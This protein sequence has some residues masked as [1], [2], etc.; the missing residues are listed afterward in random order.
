MSNF[1]DSFIKE[2]LVSKCYLDSLKCFST[3]IKHDRDISFRADKFCESILNAINSHNLT[4]IIDLFNYMNCNLFSKLE[5][6]HLS[7]LKKIQYGI[8]K[9]YLVT[10][11]INGRS[12]KVQDFFSQLGTELASVVE[13]K[14]WFGK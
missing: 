6:N 7:I 10:S 13:W 1:G 11:F 9:F 3:E 14:D 12:D 4:Q 8:Y 2:Y 5:Q